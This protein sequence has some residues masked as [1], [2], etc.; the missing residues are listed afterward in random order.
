MKTT[1]ATLLVDLKTIQ[2]QIEEPGKNRLSA[3]EI[4]EIADKKLKVGWE[5]A[6]QMVDCL[7]K[8]LTEPD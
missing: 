8:N 5:F 3:Q 1:L 7:N 6:M 2:R 4:S